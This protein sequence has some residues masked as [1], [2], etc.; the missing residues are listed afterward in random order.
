MLCAGLENVLCEAE[1]AEDPDEMNSCAFMAAGKEN[2]VSFVFGDS[3]KKVPA[4]LFSTVR[5][6]L[7]RPGVL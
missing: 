4:D 2:G 7:N 6:E 1:A 3:E 5:T